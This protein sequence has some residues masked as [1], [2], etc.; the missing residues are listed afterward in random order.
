M[1]LVINRFRFAFN[2]LTMG[3]PLHCKLNAIRGA[4]FSAIELWGRDLIEHPD[5]L[6]RAAEL[7]RHSR[8][9]VCDYKLFR[10]FEGAP[11]WLRES[12]IEEAK[13]LIAQMREVGANLLIVCSNTSPDG[14]SDV[15]AMA[16]DLAMLGRLA[17]PSGIN[18]G[19]EGL[20]WGRWINTYE[21]AWEIVERADAPNVGLVIDSFHIFARHSSLARLVSIPSDKIF[22]VQLSDYLENDKQVVNLAR[23]H[24]VFPGEGSHDIPELVAKLEAIG[25]VGDYTFEVYNDDYVV[26]EPFDVAERAMRSVRWLQDRCEQAAVTPKAS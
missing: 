7:V 25:Y 1:R 6:R 16:R 3:G 22:L 24:R 9:R 13:T 19:Y 10:D 8:L 17:E 23:H 26:A 12:K 5:G 20:S 4:G 11:S 18:I 15:G 2:T 14:V 21:R